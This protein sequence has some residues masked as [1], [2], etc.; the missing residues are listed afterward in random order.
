M[1]THRRVTRPIAVACAVAAIAPSAAFA[2]PL[3][4]D[5]PAPDST[6]VELEPA[7]VVREIHTGGDTTLAVILSGAALVVAAAGAG[8][9]GRSQRRVGRI[10]GPQA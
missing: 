8:V 9:A 7:P 4:A 1:F 5:A 6:A 2:R 3:P 10:A